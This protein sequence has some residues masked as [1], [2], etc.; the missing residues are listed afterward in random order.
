MDQE[1]LRD[2]DIVAIARN[3]DSSEWAIVVM[4]ILEGI[5]VKRFHPTSKGSVELQPQSINP[6]HEPIESDDDTENREIV[7][8][9]VGVMIG[10]SSTEVSSV[11]G[12]PRGSVASPPNV[13]GDSMMRIAYLTLTLHLVQGCA[14]DGPLGPVGEMVTAPITAPVMFVS[15]KR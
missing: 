5:T 11:G 6:E 8:V 14:P 9:V 15:T 2:G 3:P 4:R 12:I 13:R 1:N 10:A 7:G